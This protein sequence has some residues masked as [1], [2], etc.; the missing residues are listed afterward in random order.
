LKSRYIK[1]GSPALRGC[2]DGYEW[3]LLLETP[4]PRDKLFR[5]TAYR[6][7]E[8]VVRRVHAEARLRLTWLAGATDNRITLDA[9]PFENLSEA[10]EVAGLFRNF[11]PWLLLPSR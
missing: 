2:P 1:R 4:S 3:A 10:S 11:Y 9:F 5:A 8:I 6:P 7:A